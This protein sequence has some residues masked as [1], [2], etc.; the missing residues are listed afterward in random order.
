MANGVELAHAIESGMRAEAEEVYRVD[1]VSF[2]G[3]PP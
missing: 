3:A 2:G 1:V